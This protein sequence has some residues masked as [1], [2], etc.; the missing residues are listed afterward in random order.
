MKHIGPYTALNQF[1]AILPSN[2]SLTADS[3]FGMKT[4]M[5]FNK[6]IPLTFSMPDT[7]GSGMWKLFGHS[8]KFKEYRTFT[9]GKIMITV[10]HDDGIVKTAST[11]FSIVNASAHITTSK[12]ALQTNIQE[13]KLKLSMEGIEILNTLP[14]EDLKKLAS[15]LGYSSSNFFYSI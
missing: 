15:A 6:S 4:W 8:L 2:C 13:P 14:H 11:C 1:K 5:E 10:F 7:Q 12:Q 3:W 9:N